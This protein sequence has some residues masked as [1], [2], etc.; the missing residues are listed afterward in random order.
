MQI[1]E[2]IIYVFDKVIGSNIQISVYD[3][4]DDFGFLKVNF[5]WFSGDV[6][7]LPSY[8]IYISK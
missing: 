3:K 5:P 1:A 6:P 2:W 4:R 7:G 8:S